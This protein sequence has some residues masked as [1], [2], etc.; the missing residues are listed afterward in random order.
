M[1]LFFASAL[2][3]LAVAGVIS[4]PLL[5]QPLEPYA[6]EPAP[7]EA[8]TE[9]DAL[10]DALSDL[11]DALRAGKLSDDDYAAQRQRLELRY[12]RVVEG[13]EAGA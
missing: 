4:Y 1:W 7:D 3:L 5:R 12:I 2:M 10:L 8:L 11:E 13:R 6:P 9:R